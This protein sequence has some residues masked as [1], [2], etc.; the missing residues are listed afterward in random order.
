MDK[1]NLNLQKNNAK[2]MLGTVHDIFKKPNET[3]VYIYDSNLT[4]NVFAT[5]KGRCHGSDDYYFIKI[6]T[7]DGKLVDKFEIL[8]SHVPSYIVGGEPYYIGCG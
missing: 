6:E 4:V 7:L 5:Y 8:N 2:C 1:C 3:G